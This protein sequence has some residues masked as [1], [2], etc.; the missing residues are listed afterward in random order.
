M[1]DDSADAAF[2]VYAAQRKFSDTTVERW[3][4]LDAADAAALSGL[5]HD[6]RLGENQLRDLWQWAEEIAERDKISIAT[7]LETEPVITLRRRKLGRNDKLKLIKTALQRRRFPQLAA[8]E[9]RLAALVRTLALPRTIRVVL[10]EH[11]EGEEVRVEIVV[12]DAAALRQAAAQ[13]LAAAN[14][15]ACAALFDALGEAP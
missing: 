3:Q 9:D 10:P 4:R 5:T 12:R 1:R 15:P 7:V 14:T 8:A 6:L 13:L 11:L 2:R